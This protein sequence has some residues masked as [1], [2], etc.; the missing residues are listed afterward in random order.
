MAIFDKN[1]IQKVF[2]LK[3][4]NKLRVILTLV[5]NVFLGY[6]NEKGKAI[7]ARLNIYFILY[8]FITLSNNFFSLVVNYIRKIL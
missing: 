6:L 5:S 8:F 7:V 1:L 3:S 4:S 2:F